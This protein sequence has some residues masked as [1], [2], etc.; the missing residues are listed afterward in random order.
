[1]NKKA[2]GIGIVVFIAIFIALIV[3]APIILDIIRTPMTKFSAAIGNVS[4]GEQAGAEVAT[5]VNRTT[6]MWDMVILFFF[7]LNVIILLLSAFFIDT[8]PAFVIIY[9]LLCFFLVV[10][11]PN[12][13]D[14]VDKVWD[15]QQFN[16]ETGLHLDMTR[17]LKDNFGGVILSIIILSGIIM[18]AKIKYLGNNF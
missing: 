9:I 16:D 7:L 13:M 2:Q 1:M 4:G 8:H 5:I 3:A 6:S 17:F 14:A 12:V 11:V 15:V 10:F 18:Y